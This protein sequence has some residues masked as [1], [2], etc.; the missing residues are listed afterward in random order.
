MSRPD[1]R[2]QD[3]PL[4]VAVVH[5]FYSSRQTSGENRV[6]EQ[7]LE[8]LRRR[9]HAVG[10][11]AQRTD[12]RERSKAYPL[13][14]AATVATGWGPNPL[15]ELREFE[16][17]VVYV[18]NLFPNFG[19]TWVSRWPGPLVAV[20]HNYRAMCAPGTFH[21]DGHVCTDC[22]EARFSGPAVRHAC[23]R[24]SRLATLP[25]AAGVRFGADP[26]LRRADRIVVLNPIMRRLYRQA[27]VEESRIETVPNFLGDPAAPGSGEGPWLFVGRLTEAK[28]ILDLVRTWPAGVPLV[29]VGSGPLRAE[30]E[31]CAPP[32]VVLLG[33]QPAARVSELMRSARGLVFP[34]RWFEGFP[35]VYL[36]A[37]SAGTPVLAWEP[38]SVAGMVREEGTGLVVED[39][40]EAL[41]LAEQT[42]P[43]MRQRC[44]AVY[45]ERY[46]EE[47]WLSAIEGL[48]HEVMSSRSA[49]R[50]AGTDADV[51][52][53]GRALPGR[54]ARRR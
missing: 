8:S 40:S 23:Y 1:P 3:A 34:S 47:A 10:L 22:F 26:V 31:Q 37:L 13:M 9:G 52:S 44:R 15:A 6:V 5:S 12:D 42:F 38:S 11:F 21:R 36:E 32:G 41:P 28:G 17:D 48:F 46:T 18:H 19:R 2:A 43:S 14:A 25:V 50:H 24:G 29:V 53:S 45:E 20:M 33:E 35:M 30:L 4:R 49:A 27:G 16:P 51:R 39:L 7:Q 54:G